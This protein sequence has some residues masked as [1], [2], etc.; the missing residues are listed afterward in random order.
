M[1]PVKLPYV[2]AVHRPLVAHGCQGALPL[3]DS[4]HDEVYSL[5]DALLFL[6]VRQADG[7]I[8]Y[9]CSLVAPIRLLFRQAVL[10]FIFNRK[11]AKVSRF[12]RAKRIEEVVQHPLLLPAGEAGRRRRAKPSTRCALST[13]PTRASD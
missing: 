2:A 4:G 9:V 7:L 10:V 1:L 5:T 8:S 3:L 11:E 12:Q 6:S 13:A